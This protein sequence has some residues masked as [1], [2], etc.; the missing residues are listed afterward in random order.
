MLIVQALGGLSAV[1]ASSDWTFANTVS[2]IYKKYPIS[3]VKIVLLCKTHF[4]WSILDKKIPIFYLQIVLCQFITLWGPMFISSLTL[5]IS[6]PGFT[7]GYEPNTKMS[8]LA[9]TCLILMDL[10]VFY[11]HP[12]I[13]KC[14][15][16]ILKKQQEGIKGSRD[17]K[18]R[19]EYET[20]SKTLIRLKQQFYSFKK[21]E[22]NFETIVQMTLRC[23]ISDFCLLSSP[24]NK[25]T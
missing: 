17:L 24:Q 12:I 1:L 20:N 14:R 9:S 11:L 18:L 7:F 2:A 10:A 25:R 8:C 3:L 23:E 19:Q 22:L 6:N 16:S 13:L 5:S 21:M 15:I 4:R